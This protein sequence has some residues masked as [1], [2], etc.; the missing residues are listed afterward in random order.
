QMDVKIRDTFTALSAT[1]LERNNEQF[2]LLADAKMK[3]LREQLERYEVQIKSLEK[4]R[5]EA[6][7]GLNQRLAAMQEFEQQLSQETRQLVSA[8]RQP[9]I[10]GKWG[11]VSLRN[12]V[13]MTGMS[14]Y[15]DFEEQVSVR[16]DE[17]RLRPDMIV[18][19]PGNRSLV[20][21]A[22]VNASAYLDAIDAPD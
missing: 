15:C 9:G 18:R 5:A 3:P 19:L 13:E 14:A 7:G 20:I 16:G 8:L 10:K 2:V 1:A 4:V 21:D 6:Y 11:E 12:L 22:K 17:G